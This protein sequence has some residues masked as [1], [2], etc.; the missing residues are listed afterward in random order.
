MSD[1]THLHT[2]CKLCRQELLEYFDSWIWSKDL[3]G[4]ICDVC[5]MKEEE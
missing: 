1:E 3:G 2:E 4:Y 5:A